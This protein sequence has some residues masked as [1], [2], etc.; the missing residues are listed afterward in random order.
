MLKGGQIPGAEGQKPVWTAQG[1][2]LPKEKG[3]EP[4]PHLQVALQLLAD[5]FVVE[6]AA[7]HHERGLLRLLH[8]ELRAG[9]AGLKTVLWAPKGP[10]PCH[11]GGALPH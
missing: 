5:E 1:T 4:L 8:H 6:D 10:L 9:Q 7:G 11:I 3:Q 2:G